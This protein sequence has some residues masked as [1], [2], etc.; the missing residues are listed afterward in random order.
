MTSDGKKIKSVLVV[1]AGVAGVHAA[2]NLAD[3]DFKVYLLEKQPH[4]GGKLVKLY[5]TAEDNFAL[6]MITPVLL[7]AVNNP[8]IEIL[9]LGELEKIEGEPGDF[10]VSIKRTPRYVDPIKCVTCGLCWPECPVQ[11]SSEFNYGLGK[12]NAIGMPYAGAVPNK[13]SIDPNTCLHMKG[14]ECT[15]CA[16]VCP[17]DAI[18]LDAKET[19][20]ELKVGGIVLT[21]GVEPYYGSSEAK[22][23][24]HGTMANVIDNF[25]MDR[26]VSIYGPTKGQVTRPSDGEIAHKIA[27][28]QCVGSRK[29][30]DDNLEYC[31]S[32]CCMYAIRVAMSTQAKDVENDITLFH[33]DIMAISKTHEKVFGEAQENGIKFIR[34]NVS[35][36][37]ED[38]ETHN[39]TLHY[40]TEAGEESSEVFELVVLSLGLVPSQNGVTLAESAGMSLNSWRFPELQENSNLASSGIAVGGSFKSLEDTPLAVADSQAAAMEVA[41]FLSDAEPE[42]KK[43]SPPPELDVSG[44]PPRIGV[45]VCECGGIIPKVVN[46]KQL[47][48]FAGTLDGVEDTKIIQYACFSEGMEEI[49]KSIKENEI[50]RVVMVAC[51]YRSHLPRFQNMIRQVG[52]NK[53]LV[54]MVN[55]RELCA[56][57]N[58]EEKEKATERMKEE[59]KGIVAKVKGLAPLP[60]Y[61]RD[62]VQRSLVLGGGVAG[63]TAALSM[64]SNGI[65]VD[66]AEKTE[67]LGGNAAQLSYS[68]KGKRVSNYIDGLV[69]QVNENPLINVIL[70]A[71]LKELKGRV[72]Q[73]SSRINTPSETYE[74]EYGAIIVATGGREHVPHGYLY[75]DNEKVITQRELEKMI[76]NNDAALKGISSAAVI[77]CVGSRDK[78][79]PYCSRVCCSQSIKNTLKLKE[80]N[81]DVKITHL[82]RDIRT[83]FLNDVQYQ[84]AQEAGVTFIRYDEGK[85]LHIS[86]DNGLLV[87]ATD[88]K[89]GEEVT[90]KP[91]LII[92]NAAIIPGEDNNDLSRLLDVPLGEYNFFEEEDYMTFTPVDFSKKGVYLCGL[93]HGPKTI[94]ESVAQAKAAAIRALSVITK[95]KLVHQNVYAN[96]NPGKCIACLTCVRVCP[97]GVPFINDDGVAEIIPLECRACGVCVSSCPNDAIEL[98]SFTDY[99]VL[100]HIETMF[101]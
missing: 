55:A 75:K 6:G 24:G 46:T 27:F 78:E 7:T 59:I 101:A 91:D 98:K 82:H 22:K 12:R 64:A 56:W 100:P 79:R 58:I 48:E 89:T 53:F 39:L 70:N 97:F 61:T 41:A 17:T 57:V 99:D 21:P 15:K 72:G 74:N 77:H 90:L 5:R 32:V 10:T 86:Q 66:I 13:P 95:E 76:A 35:S 96:V 40:D 87:E 16:D 23:L 34:G 68:T 51:S 43:S 49:Q 84:K 4:I 44:I 14:E 26:L 18:N 88:T 1:G 94:D 47:Y 80:S 65:P 36:I 71:E 60:V 81:L 92:L 67:T 83:Y 25:Q 28:I 62:V 30:G 31:S 93:S 37:T 52:L 8:N 20:Q 33:N 2:L 50:N 9:T 38:P 85:G 3:L 54:E 11:V 19:I 29:S 63:M 42:S 69:K 73:F 45:Y